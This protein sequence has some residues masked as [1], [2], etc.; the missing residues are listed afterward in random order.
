[1]VSDF[2][3]GEPAEAGWRRL[4]MAVKTFPG[5]DGQ[6]GHCGDSDGFFRSHDAVCHREH[7]LC[8]VNVYGDVYVFLF[9]DLHGTVSDLFHQRAVNASR[10]CPVRVP[11]IDERE[12][13]FVRIMDVHIRVRPLVERRGIP[14]SHP[15]LFCSPGSEN[16]KIQGITVSGPRAPARTV[17][18]LRDDDH[19]SFLDYG[20][21]DKYQRSQESGRFI[22]MRVGHEQYLSAFLFPFQEE[23]ICI[24]HAPFQ[25]WG[26]LTQ[27]DDFRDSSACDYGHLVVPVFKKRNSPHDHER[28]DYDQE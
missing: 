20:V 1:M 25:S 23:Y 3:M 4:D 6:G 22:G 2:P 17:V 13:L 11:H 18:E 19:C 8:P 24:R 26:E 16:L 9:H 10:P 12:K 7:G 14:I 21:L 28:N 15:E 5:F 27:F